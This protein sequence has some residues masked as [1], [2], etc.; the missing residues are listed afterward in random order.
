MESDENTISC[1]IYTGIIADGEDFDDYIIQSQDQLNE[2]I[3][4]IAINL[5]EYYNSSESKIKAKPKSRTVPN[6]GD[7]FLNKMVS[8]N[9]STQD[10]IIIRN[11]RIDYIKYNRFNN[12][13]I[14]FYQNQ[15]TDNNVYSAA[16]TSCKADYLVK[17]NAKPNYYCSQRVVNSNS[18]IKPPK[19]FDLEDR[20]NN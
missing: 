17:G 1:D 4:Y 2:F 10:V 8:I 9:F 18:R 11:A 14:V 15:S 19:D 3:N 16:I 7:I 20:I 6:L 12:S 13:F 5:I